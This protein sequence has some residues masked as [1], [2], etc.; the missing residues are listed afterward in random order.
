MNTILIILV[1]L[2]LIAFNIAFFFWYVKNINRLW[3]GIRK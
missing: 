1:M 3:R 2:A